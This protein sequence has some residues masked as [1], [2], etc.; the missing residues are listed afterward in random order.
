MHNSKWKQG[1]YTPKFPNKYK[2]SLPIVY[3]SSWERRV[4]FFLDNHS[5]I[6]SWGSESVIIKYKFQIDNKI[7]RYYI[8]VDFITKNKYGE[9]KRYIIE[10]K[11]DEQTKPPKPPKNKNKKAITRYN[12]ALIDFQRNQDKWVAAENWARSKGYIF[13]IWTE[14]TLGI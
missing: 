7:H 13:S 11:P 1:K 2:G 8:D 9:E 10:I 5:S 12:Q 14:K 3:R 6:I 4:F